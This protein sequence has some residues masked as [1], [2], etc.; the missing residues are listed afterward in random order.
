MRVSVVLDERTEKILQQLA[1]SRGG[2]G[3]RVVLEALATLAAT[4]M[5]SDEAA[6]PANK[7][8]CKFAHSKASPFR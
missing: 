5:C 3:K 7:S 4:P 8:S 1:R 6:T 2:N